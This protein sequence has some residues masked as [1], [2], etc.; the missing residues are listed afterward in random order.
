MALM[1]DEHDL[2]RTFSHARHHMLDALRV[3]LVNVGGILGER[4]NEK[5]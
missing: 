3:E 4:Y 1:R 2:H 5:L